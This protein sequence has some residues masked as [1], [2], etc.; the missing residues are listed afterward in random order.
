MKND[1]QLVAA[2]APPLAIQFG[3]WAGR[4]IQLS[5]K[6]ISVNS[7]SEA[8]NRWNQIRDE[9]EFRASNSPLVFIVNTVTGEQIA[10][11]S[12]NGRVWGCDGKEILCA[13]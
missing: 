6:V 9:Q 13:S 8:S 11:I 12:Y 3:R 1:T 2:S 10:K 7:L 5:S 4:K